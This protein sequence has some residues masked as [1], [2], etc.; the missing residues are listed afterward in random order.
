MDRNN[1]VIRVLNILYKFITAKFGFTI[2]ELSNEFQVHPKTIRRDLKAIKN[3]PFHLI[4]DK[5]GTDK[6]YKVLEKMTLEGNSTLDRST[7]FD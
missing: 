6:K 5:N 2:Q 1:Q 3:S 4:Q 7:D